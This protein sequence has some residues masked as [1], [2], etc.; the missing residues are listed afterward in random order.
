MPQMN[1]FVRL[2]LTKLAKDFVLFLLVALFERPRVT[3][4]SLSTTRRQILLQPIVLGSLITP[5]NA[6]AARGAAELDFEFYVRDLIG[7]NRPEGN[8][9][10]STLPTLAPPRTL[11]LFFEKI[12][13]KEC[14]IECLATQQLI[15]QIQRREK[16]RETTFLEKEIQRQ[17]QTIR[18]GARKSFF[19]RAPWESETMT[20][21]YFFDLTAYSFWKTAAVMLPNFADRDMFVRNVGRSIY[22]S[23]RDEGLLKTKCRDES[24]SSCIPCVVEVLDFFVST[25]FCKAY[26]L[27]EKVDDEYLFLD[28]IDN[29]AWSKGVSVDCLLSIFESATLGSSLQ[30]TGEQSRFIPDLVGPTIAAVWDPQSSV[31]W[32]SYFVDPEYRPNPK[33]YFPNEQLFQYTLAKR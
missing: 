19:S 5:Q 14:S 20:D 32:E 26:R 2:R 4:L 23:L 3:S 21:Q 22:T 29:Q 33:D 16:K 30:I 9:Q 25:N 11:S 18:E 17:V 13:N 12:L 10:A 27:G 1:R 15:A 24:L 28:D 31:Q 8:V 7:G 6:N